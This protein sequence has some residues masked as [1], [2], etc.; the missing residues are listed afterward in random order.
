[1]SSECQTARVQIRPDVLSG[2]YLGPNCLQRYSTDD[3]SR[4]GKTDLF[5]VIAETDRIFRAEGATEIRHLQARNRL[6]TVKG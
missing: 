5:S 4:E 3:T 6:G 1:M 2:F